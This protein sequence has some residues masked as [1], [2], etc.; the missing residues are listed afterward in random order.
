MK[1]RRKIFVVGIAGLVALCRIAVIIAAL[2][3]VGLPT[4]Y[5]NLYD[6]SRP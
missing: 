2:I 1:R 6:T 4:R 3:N 5:R